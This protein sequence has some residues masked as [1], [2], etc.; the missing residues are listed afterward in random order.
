MYKGTPS[1]SKTKLK[2]NQP[3]RRFT[4]YVP[5]KIYRDHMTNT[6]FTVNHLGMV[7][8]P[9]TVEILRG[10]EAPG[11]VASTATAAAAPSLSP[12]TSPEPQEQ[13]TANVP[14]YM[15]I[16]SIPDIFSDDYVPPQFILTAI[17]KISKG[18]SVEDS[19]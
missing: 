5:G 12:S 3:G 14:A 4:Q 2:L 16:D 7:V 18:D 17:R 13:G 10:E 19:G 1:S 6:N 9:S 15:G 8:R 11:P